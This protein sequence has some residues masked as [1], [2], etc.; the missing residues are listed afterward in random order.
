M[1]KNRIFKE[2]EL[3]NR[4]RVVPSGT[5]SGQP[6]LIGGIRPA[7]AITDRGDAVKTFSLGGLTMGGFPSGGVGLA[8]NEASVAFDGTWEFL[9]TGATPATAQDDPIYIT[10]AGA[11][12]TMAGSNTRFGYVDYPKDYHKA[13]GRLP[14][15]IGA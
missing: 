12:T 3:K 9:V 6:L 13:A 8:P 10:G 4:V 11:L 5:V 15:R 7:V 1:A 14:V 2:T